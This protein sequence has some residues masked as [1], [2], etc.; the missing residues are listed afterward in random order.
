LEVLQYTFAEVAPTGEKW[1]LGLRVMPEFTES[2]LL[3]ISE[4]E[5]NP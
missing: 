1:V 5:A 4:R 2:E 3:A